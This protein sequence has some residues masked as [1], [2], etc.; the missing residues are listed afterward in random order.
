MTEKLALAATIALGVLVKI[1]E[2]RIYC[3]ICCGTDCEGPRSQRHTRRDGVTTFRSTPA[4]RHVEL[5]LL[6]CLRLQTSGPS[7][8]APTMFVTTTCVRLSGV[9]ANRR[10]LQF[11]T[12]PRCFGLTPSCFAT[13]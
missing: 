1:G 13:S 9:H 2:Q 10:W 6:E 12:S 11:N 3:G 4:I 5:N 8:Y 7:G